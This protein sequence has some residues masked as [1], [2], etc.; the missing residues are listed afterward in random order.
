[1][2]GSAY[3]A[4][5]PRRQLR[6]WALAQ[7]VPWGAAEGS[8]SH[9]AMVHLTG[10]GAMAG[11]IAARTSGPLLRRNAVDAASASPGSEAL[12][13]GDGQEGH[14]ASKWAT[15]IAEWSRSHA[16]SQDRQDRRG[17]LAP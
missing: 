17:R 5:P 12:C 4:G 14:N 10:A 6:T 7:T 1:V 8:V 13:E 2:P 15:R 16:C 11:R 3:A 9:G